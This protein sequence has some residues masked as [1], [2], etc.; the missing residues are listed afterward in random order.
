MKYSIVLSTQPT[1]FSALAYSGKIAENIARIKEYGFDAVELAV[2]DPLQLDVELITTTL[3]KNEL[4][5][6]AIG[7]GQA[8]TEEKLSFTNSN[9]EIRK[10]AIERI[11]AQVLLAEKLNSLVIIGLIRGKKEDN[12]SFSEVENYFFDAICE[13]A[14]FNNKIKFK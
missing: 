12:Q 8:F 5:V 11:K 13:C 14:E 6:S 10:K 4:P 7:T 2:R 3:K 1:S 9:K